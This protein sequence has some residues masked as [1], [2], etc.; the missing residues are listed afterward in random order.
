L[1]AACSAR[2]V[3]LDQLDQLGKVGRVALDKRGGG[4]LVEP[5]QPEALLRRA[6]GRRGLGFLR[7][8]AQRAIRNRGTH[9][10][11]VGERTLATR[12]VGVG[13]ISTA[14]AGAE[15]TSAPSMRS[16][17]GCWCKQR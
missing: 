12:F 5:A 1:P 16:R 6:R 14:E 4:L 11:I 8:E 15:G 2:V 17:A 7:D 3:L 13:L 10:P 9:T